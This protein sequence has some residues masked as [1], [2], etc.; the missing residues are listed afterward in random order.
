M[1][2][3]ETSMLSHGYKTSKDYEKLYELIKA[4]RIVCFVTHKKDRGRDGYKL[5]DIC[6]S[7]V[8]NSDSMIDIGARGVSYITAMDFED[9]N[10]KDDFISQCEAS[11]L[12]YIEPNFYKNTDWDKMRFEDLK[13]GQALER[14]DTATETRCVVVDISTNS[15]LLKDDEGLEKR[16]S[17]DEVSLWKRK[18]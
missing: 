5:Q 2:N 12:E 4:Q 6:Q 9:R 11:E 16:Y 7:Q 1:A 3:K 15:F 17:Q 8:V 10:I 18:L 14:T 13:V